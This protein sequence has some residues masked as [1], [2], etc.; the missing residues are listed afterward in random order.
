MKTVN[1]GFDVAPF[2]FPDSPPHEARFEEARDVEVV[3]AAFAGPVPRTARLQYLRKVWPHERVERAADMD[4]VRPSQFGWLKMDD[5]FTPE[6]AD[7]ATRVTRVG[8]RTLRFTFQPL[9]MEIPDFPDAAQY[10]VTYRRTVAVRVEGGGVP[11]RSLRVFTRSRVA[12]SALRVE[13]HAGRRTPARFIEVSGY[14]AVIRRVTAGAGTRAARGRVVVNPAQQGAFGLEIEH[15]IPAH[16]HAHDDGHVLFMLGGDAF[17][18]SLTALAAEG[19][20]WYPDAGVFIVRSDD[21]ETFAQYRARTQGA[22]SIRRDVGARPE[23]SLAGAMNGQPRPHPI[24]Y[25]FGC[26]HARQKFWLE[27][28]GDI[29]MNAWLVQRQ[30]GRDTPKWRND[31]N[32]RFLFGFDRWA[33]EARFN[34]PWPAMAY[35]LQF[36]RGDVRVR[37][38]CFAVPLERS[39]LAGEPAPDD[40]MVALVRFRFENTGDSPATA[41]L[42]MAYSPKAPRTVNRRMELAGGSR[43]QT[44][45]LVPLC[46]REPLTIE[47]DRVLGPW[48]DARVLRLAFQTDMAA[49]PDGA[50]IRFRKDLQPGETCELRLRIPYVAIE[51]PAELEALRGLDFDRCYGEMVRY[52]RT[53]SRK[54]AQIHTPDPHLNA[55]YAGHLPIVL[56][57]DLGHPDGSGAV[58]TS[59]GTCTYGNFTNEAAMIL[60][61]LDQRG[62]HEEVRRRLAVWVRYQGTVG[63]RGRFSDHDGV[64]FGADGMEA[65]QSYNQHHG[66]GLWSL[67]RHYLHTGDRDWFAGVA[68]SVVRAADWIVRQRRLTTGA[69]PHSR[70]WERGF[71]PAGALEDVEDCF[72]WLSTNCFTWRGLDAAATALATFG[73]RAAPRLRREANAYRRDLVRGFE[74]AR[75]HSP[76]I[77]LRDGRWIPHYP[78]RLYC[79]GRDFGWIREVLEGSVNLLLS[80]LYRADSQ[81]AGWILDDYLDTRYMNPPFGYRLDDPQTQW[82]DCGGF[83]VQPDLLAG[84]LPHLDRDEIEVYLWMFFNAWAAC[85]REEVQAMVEHPLPVLGFS[86]PAPFKTSDQANAMS[87]LA[88]MFVYERAGLLHLGRAIPRA[89]FGQDE[90]FGATGLDT[91]AG[92]VSITYRPDPAAGRIAADVL[93]EPRTPPTRVLVRFRHPQKTALR[94][95]VVNGR[96]HRNWNA[97]TG[98]VEI[99]CRAGATHITV[100]YSA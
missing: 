56:M 44:D 47:G 94:A 18:I 42:P 63:L 92:R 38:K 22:L 60:D 49:A 8:A 11:V 24:P 73:H 57:T 75:R 21:P 66:W 6:W 31:G 14:N 61:E 84:L 7:A 53:E 82:F 74:T 23:Q 90:A 96:P 46:D 41:E 32:S 4:L 39:I 71:L 69:L 81:Q 86:N 72:Y 62:L 5:Q 100:V 88:R 68:D 36:R 80:G 2:R 79:R 35:N 30:P 99:A 95:V 15:M 27:P 33:P 70:G 78:S 59:V 3:E 91:P 98:D 40:T 97:A 9:R 1:E 43:R 28:C 13:L 83:S 48:R 93:L 50:G 20:I 37:L 12:R 16:R 34:D 85:Y 58:N 17:T 25:C 55:A 29:E 76:L 51:S 10:D 87:W 65:G 52:W 26:K 77:R 64:L 45:A 67:A 89:W 19:P 54:G